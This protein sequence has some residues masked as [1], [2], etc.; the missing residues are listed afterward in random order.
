MA[1]G[2]ATGRAST[3][4][5]N[6]S[7]LFPPVLVRNAQGT[8]ISGVRLYS[9]SLQPGGGGWESAGTT[10]AHGLNSSQALYAEILG[11]A[12]DGR[13]AVGPVIYDER[14]RFG[15][16]LVFGPTGKL[17]LHLQDQ[18]G[19]A[20]SN[21]ELNLF[22]AD[23]SAP[24]ESWGNFR[25]A[26]DVPQA[27]QAVLTRRTDASGSAEFLNLPK[28]APFIVLTP[29]AAERVLAW[30]GTVQVGETPTLTLARDLQVSGR[31]V[32]TKGA[33]VVG[34]EV[35]L[36]APMG[37]WYDESIATDIAKTVTDH[38]GAYHFSALPNYQCNVSLGD[39]S[40]LAGK[41]AI[42]RSKVD[43]KNWSAESYDG[44]GLPEPFATSPDDL[45]GV[46]RHQ[47]PVF[48]LMQSAVRCDFRTFNPAIVTVDFAHPRVTSLRACSLFVS[49]P[50]ADHAE[51]AGED[52]GV[53][54]SVP[55]VLSPGT[56]KIAMSRF[57][58]Q[59]MYP[60][61]TVRVKE[62]E[63][64]HVRCSIP[65][66]YLT[67]RPAAGADAQTPGFHLFEFRA[68]G[69]DGREYDQRSL[70]ASGPVFLINFSDW[71][72]RSEFEDM[73]RLNR[74]MA[75]KVRVVGIVFDRDPA[76]L[77]AHARRSGIRHLLVGDFKLLVQQ[78]AV[79]RSV[80][81]LGNAL[82]TS[83][84]RI[85]HIWSG[86]NRSTLRQMEIDL[87]RTTGIQLSLDLSKFPAKLRVGDSS[88]SGGPGP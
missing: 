8:P 59:T 72:E 17:R 58:E 85:T 1:P 44:P 6:N 54:S 76:A 77:R 40:K 5:Q 51:G 69:S 81:V 4:F 82:L 33:P 23:K 13:I 3:S 46:V 61:A 35:V 26:P 87:R 37:E 75:G 24:L 31:V 83:D 36:K 71:K 50:T 67:I 2:S 73:N 20:I 48:A 66:R 41:R 14:E 10:N 49:N 68:W 64:R 65:N 74:M 88:M 78:I 27:V 38:L 30:H 16:K 32:T 42:I 29:L 63:N 80:Y 47:G 53:R 18:H 55:L 7:A 62:G 56:H 43:R 15:G 19:R 39:L 57:A 70:A 9:G 84:G 25:P 45:L 22:P 86:Y 11:I 79:G 52:V 28:G 21:Q 12:P 34:A 60:L